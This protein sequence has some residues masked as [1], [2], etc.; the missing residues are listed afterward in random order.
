LKI[1]R[2]AALA[3]GTFGL[4]FA[5]IIYAWSI[6]KAPFLSEFGW[7]QEA[8]G[9]NFTI[10]MICFVVGG[11]LAGF[12]LKRL[13]PQAC[14]WI[15]AALAF[16][17][18]F[19]TSRL[20]GQS[21][22]MLYIAYGVI[23]GLGIGI[24]YNLVI[25]TVSQRFS[26]R[27][28]TASGVLMMGFGASTLVLGTLAG[29]LFQT[30]AW[31]DVFL[32][33]AFC[34]LGIFALCSFFLGGGKDAGAPA[35]AG[36]EAAKT[37]AQTDA[38]TALAAVPDSPA[39]PD[40]ETR[41]MLRS[42]V[43]WRFYILQVLLGAIGTC[44]ISFAK[45]VSLFV[46]NPENFAVLVVG[47]FAVCNGLGR[48]IC[49][50]LYDRCGGR[51]TILISCAIATTGAALA[52]VSVAVASPLLNTLALLLAGIAYGFVPTCS[53]GFSKSMFGTKYFPL[54]FSVT[55]SLLVPASFSSAIGGRIY[56]ASGSFLGVF[57][58]ALGLAVGA[59]GMY[60]SVQKRL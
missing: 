17:G 2:G 33:L 35:E 10:M 32:L 13:K 34:A 45:D 1:H 24:F 38:A 25:S 26:G 49:G 40:V 57:A 22:A 5:G 44:V 30:M 56:E 16:I 28:T 55:N 60:L 52:V 9:A 48:I 20:S 29:Q 7:D 18:F 43:F 42:S 12:L 21:V 47:L 46:G 4:L 23:L 19:L 37:P 36:A 53:S 58:M 15:A 51:K 3:A 11:V 54:N 14:A 31:R 6:L 8:L 50:M 41:Q 59:I 27:A 39:V